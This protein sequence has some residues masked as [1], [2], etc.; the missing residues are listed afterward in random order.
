VG[1]PTIS[2][3]TSSKTF[4]NPLSAFLTNDDRL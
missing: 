4:V 1:T 3:G 2:T